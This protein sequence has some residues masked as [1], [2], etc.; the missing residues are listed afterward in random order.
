VFQWLISFVGTVHH[1]WRSMKSKEEEE[2]EEVFYM[3][4]QEVL[5]N[6]LSIAIIAWL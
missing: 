3:F 2:E 6:A 5:W 4:L 1:W